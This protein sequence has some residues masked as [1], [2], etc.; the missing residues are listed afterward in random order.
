MPQ[1]EGW[2]QFGH[3]ALDQLSVYTAF[4]ALDRIESQVVYQG[5]AGFNT[6]KGLVD[7]NIICSLSK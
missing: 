3:D 4:I 6:V 2:K 5:C 7:L 1:Y